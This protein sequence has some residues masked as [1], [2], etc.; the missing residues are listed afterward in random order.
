MAA[1]INILPLGDKCAIYCADI[2]RSFRRLCHT[3]FATLM[4]AFYLSGMP[5]IDCLLY[6]LYRD[7]DFITLLLMRAIDCL[8]LLVAYQNLASSFFF[9]IEIGAALMPRH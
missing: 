3:L 7:K 1:R 6:L 5:K 2:N 4:S 8:Q 9:D